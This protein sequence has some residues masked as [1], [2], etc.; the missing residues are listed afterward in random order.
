MDVFFKQGRPPGRK[1]YQYLALALY[2]AALGIFLLSEISGEREIS[3]SIASR[4]A[5][6]ILGKMEDL[7]RWNL[8]Y[9]KVFAVM[10]S[11]TPAELLIPPGEVETS[12]GRKL[13]RVHFPTMI[14]KIGGMGKHGQSVSISIS[15]LKAL[16]PA[17]EPDPWERTSLLDLELGA[18]ERSGFI[19]DEHGHT[20]FRYM[21]P[22]VVEDHCLA[23]HQDQG[24]QAGH[25]MAGITASVPAD[26][27][28]VRARTHSFQVGTVIFLL[29]LAGI[30]LAVVLERHRARDQL[31]I[32]EL[33]EMTLVD[34]L[35]GLNNRRG[36][37][38]LA[39]QQ[40]RYAER[41]NLK[42]S[43]LFMDL[44]GF[45]EINDTYGHE[46]GDAALVRFSN[47]LLSTF[48]TSDIVSRFGGDEFVVLALDAPPDTNNTIINRVKENIE[49]DNGRSGKPYRLSVSLGTAPFDP[50]DPHTLEHLI[51]E[52][53]GKMYT[54]KRG[55]KQG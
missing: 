25:I 39:R 36:F 55:R 3:R 16:D 40:I 23:C 48:R 44:D 42:A 50:K 34:P 1:G 11:E 10:G 9:E 22:I 6:G 54:D 38:T 41:N 31:R 32:R 13:S 53:D 30:G 4:Q 46:D 7:A 18:P 49:R 8:A 19:R 43:L 37:L 27:L 21:K 12:D 5:V 17:H 35:T 29:W 33:D 2:T 26:E 15:S 14:S 51:L 28:V 47:V 20:F 45:K 52:A 24:Y